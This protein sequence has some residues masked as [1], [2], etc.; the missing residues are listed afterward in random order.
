[1][2]RWLLLFLLVSGWSC[3]PDINKKKGPA[4]KFFDINGLI[5]Q[6]V[7]LLDSV[8]PFLL[9]TATIDGVDEQ[10]LL[11]SLNHSTWTKELV[12]FKSADINNPKLADSYQ[13]IET[14]ISGLKTFIYTSKFPKTTKTDS[15][16]I[17]FDV[18][19]NN[20]IKIH[21]H[22]RG[23]NALFESDKT[24]D[25][26]FKTTNNQSMLTNYSIEGWQ[27]MTSKD[28]TTYLIE[29]IVK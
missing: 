21:A 5:E 26:T 24:L 6:Q 16:T 9:K 15:L 17:S 27:K 7:N 25:M 2:N 10:N 11:T 29:G 22:V 8:S 19:G 4:N 13:F 28:S 18:T 1:M 12:I 14:K 20:P 3:G 23:S